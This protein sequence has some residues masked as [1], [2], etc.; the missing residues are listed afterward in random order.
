MGFSANVL[1]TPYWTT[2]W[3]VAWRVISATP[4]ASLAPQAVIVGVCQSLSQ[5]GSNRHLIEESWC[6]VTIKPSET[7]VQPAQRGPPPSSRGLTPQQ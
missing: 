2:G 6:V 4:T 1:R 7:I 5:K 3:W